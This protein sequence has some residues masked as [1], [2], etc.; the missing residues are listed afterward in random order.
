MS[1]YRYLA[2]CK[3]N[4]MFR[5]ANPAVQYLETTNDLHATH[6]LDRAGTPYLH[7]IP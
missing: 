2:A 5:E 3:L 6:A 1:M 7:T 4:R